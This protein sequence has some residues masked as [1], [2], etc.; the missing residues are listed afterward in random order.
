MPT[1]SRLSRRW[2]AGFLPK[3]IRKRSRS[4]AQHCVEFRE[5]AIDPP[6]AEVVVDSLPGRVLAGKQTPGTSST[7]QDVEETA[8]KISR[9]LWILCRPRHF[10]GGTRG[11]ICSHSAS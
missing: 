10:G 6:L 2:A 9:G 5:G 3:Q 8:F 1:G 11:S 7:P 4:I